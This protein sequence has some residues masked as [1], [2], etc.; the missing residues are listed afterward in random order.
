M[1]L[2]LLLAGCSGNT[3]NGDALSAHHTAEKV[4]D[5][6]SKMSK[7]LEIEVS[8]RTTAELEAIGSLAVWLDGMEDGK[9][10]CSRLS[11]WTVRGCRPLSALSPTWR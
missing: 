5:G 2:A 4:K 7:P 10:V 11:M 1:L 6:W 3:R 9:A 8:G